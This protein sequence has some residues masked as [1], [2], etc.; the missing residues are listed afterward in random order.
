VEEQMSVRS[1][2]GLWFRH[3]LVSWPKGRFP[4]RKNVHTLSALLFVA[5]LL[6][7]RVSWA[8]GEAGHRMIGQVAAQTLPTELPAF[9]RAAAPQLA[10]LNPEPDRWRDAI[11]SSLDPAFNAAMAPEHYLDMEKLNDRMVQAPN[12][13][14]YL[15]AIHASG[16]GAVAVGTLPFAIMDRFQNL[17]VDFRLWR[18]AQDD[19]TRR[20]IEQRVINDAGILGHFVADASNPHH[21]TIHHNGWVGENPLHYTTDKTFHF[22]FEDQ[23]V[24]T[25]IKVEDVLKEM[26]SRSVQI[27]ANPRA[28]MWLYV[29]DSHA[30][31][32]TLYQLDAKAPFNDQTTAEADRHFALER[33]AAGAAMLRD[34]WATAWAESEITAEQRDYLQKLKEKWANPPNKPAD[35][36]GKKSD[37]PASAPAAG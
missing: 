37:K 15:A 30:Q 18:E 34:L 27:F 21:T 11:E 20:Y 2:A 25:H 10:Y 19:V 13:D 36:P 3:Q 24:S 35:V 16:E 29:R 26:P 31:L 17:R 9:F 14:A 28:A 23:Y 22:R 32:E 7:S 5:M 1:M 33:L 12:R 4:Y 8:W 6:V